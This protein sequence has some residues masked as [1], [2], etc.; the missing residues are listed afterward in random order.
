[1]SLPWGLSVVFP[2][3]TSGRVRLPWGD[4]A[5]SLVSP[6]ADRTSKTIPPFLQAGTI[7]AGPF[8]NLLNVLV[9]CR[10]LDEVV[11]SVL[12]G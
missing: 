7:E 1:M 10:E 5:L 12:S 3:W 8:D 11:C 4:D 2:R 6:V 9:P